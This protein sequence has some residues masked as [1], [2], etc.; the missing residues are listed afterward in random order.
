MSWYILIKWLHVM[1]AVMAVGANLTY[2]IWIRRAEG[3]PLALP[4]VLRSI[5]LIDR[6][7]ANPGYLVL[8]AT[9]LTMAFTLRIPLSTPWLLTSML[10][11][12]LAA[13]IGVLAYAPLSRRQRKSLELEGFDS[14]NYRAIS[15]Q[16]NQLGSLVTVDVLLIVFLMVVKPV[17]WV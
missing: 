6:R 9:G 1:S 16:A 14:P 10:L 7:I 15:R 2:R 8:L 12:S 11:Y 13:L 5:H 4:F 3:E 17:L